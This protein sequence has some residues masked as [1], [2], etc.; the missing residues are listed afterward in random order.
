MQGVCPQAAERGRAAQRAAG[1]AFAFLGHAKL[2]IFKAMSLV[3]PRPPKCETRH[4]V[5]R[6]RVPRQVLG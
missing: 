1:A 4:P 2:P 5:T 3:R 6:S